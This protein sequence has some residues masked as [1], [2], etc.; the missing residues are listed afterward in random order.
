MRAGR[1]T[2]E[3][4]NPYIIRKNGI[5]IGILA[6]C[7]HQEDFAAGPD[8]PGI[9]YVKLLDVR[10]ARKITTHISKLSEV[11]D[12]VIVSIHW[13]PNWAPEIDKL[14]RS[15]AMKMAEAGAGLIWGHSPHHFQCIEW[16][17]KTPVI[18]SSG[19]LLNDY[20][21]DPHYRNDLQLLF[22]V[23]IQN[24]KVISIAAHPLKLDYAET[25]PLAN[26]K[27]IRWISNRLN[28]FC[29]DM[30]TPFIWREN[31]FLFQPQTVEVS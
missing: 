15:L 23:T 30:N 1:N 13:Q 7:D 26:E 20:V 3:A 19:D 4:F 22:D 16:F 10:S 28:Q 18:Y 6:F 21:V 31:H 11:V 9:S 25:R 2:D 12:F 27:D 24:N 5:R 17:G 29:G 14:Y 8:K